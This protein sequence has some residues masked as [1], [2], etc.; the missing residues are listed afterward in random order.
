MKNS[1]SKIRILQSALHSNFVLR[2]FF[3]L[4]PMAAFAHARGGE[5]TGF[6]RGVEH[7]VSGLDHVLAMVAV[8][9]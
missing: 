6:F 2:I 5:T 1:K 4:W 7:P 9:L 8:G 3:L